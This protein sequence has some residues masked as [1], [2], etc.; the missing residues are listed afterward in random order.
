MNENTIEVFLLNA[1][2]VSAVGVHI[3]FTD[4]ITAIGVLALAFY[5][6]MKGISYLKK[7]KNESRT[8]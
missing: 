8:N 1:A 3:S 6:I 5:N 7:S 4:V 2:S